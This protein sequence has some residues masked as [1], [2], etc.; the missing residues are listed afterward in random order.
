MVAEALENGVRVVSME[1]FLNY[2]GYDPGRRIWRPGITETWN[3]RSGARAPPPDQTPSDARNRVERLRES[4]AARATLCGNRAEP[5][6]RPRT[7]DEG[8]MREAER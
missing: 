5:R 7:K 2:I 3:L 4:S 8:G 6:R 1:D